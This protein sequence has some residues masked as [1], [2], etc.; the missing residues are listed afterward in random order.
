MDVRTDNPLIVQSDRTVLLEVDGPR[1]P[2]ARDALA[3]FA[4]LVKSPEHIHTYRI[5]PL[6]I[7]NAA[8]AGHSAAAMAD[9]LTRFAKYPVPQNVLR[10]IEDYASRYGRI[11]LVK[12]GDGLALESEDPL[13]VREAW[14][15]A[16][17]RKYLLERLSPNRLAVDPAMRGHVKQAMIRLGYPVEDL[18][19]Y[20]E[21]GAL[22]IALAENNGF[23][24]RDYQ[25]R[26]VEAFWAGGSARGGSGVIVLPCGAGKTIVGMASSMPSAASIPPTSGSTRGSARRAGPSPC[27]P[28]RS[29]PTA[30]R[31]PSPSS[32][33]ACSPATTGASSSTPREPAH[34]TAS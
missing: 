21:G 17:V 31:R 1:Y 10:D 16:A 2:D 6:S 32:T 14:A 4:E 11:R 3:A 29:S 23:R 5:T 15:N 25:R 27:P 13:L 33:S 22:A 12:D 34:E 30:A 9:A 8:A 18:A 24:V 26:A 28:T 7:W 20:V 19:G